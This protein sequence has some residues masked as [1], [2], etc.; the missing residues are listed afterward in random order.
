N[1]KRFVAAE[2]PTSI[3]PQWERSPKDLKGNIDRIFCAG[4]NRIVWHTFT[5][6]PKEFGLP[7]NEYFAGTH[8]NPNV[9]WWE[10]AGGFISY[11]NR[12][13][14]LL[15]QG[16]FVADVLYYYGD[17]VPNFVFLKDEYKELKFGYNWDKCSKD[18]LLDHASV[19]NG[20]LLLPDGMSYRLLVLPNEE[21][22]NLEVLKKV[23]E[24]VKQGLTVIS[25][26]P[27]RATGLTNYPESDSEIELIVKRMWG[28]VNGENVTE[29]KYG[30]GHVVWGQDVNEVLVGMEVHPDLKF[31]STNE[32]T[33]LDFI[34]RTTDNQ[35][36][37]F[38]VNRYARKGI[39]D[40]KYRYLTD[41]P[42][43][44]EQV[45]C[46]FRVTGKVPELWDP[47]TGNI[48]KQLV[49]KEEGEYT[50]IPLHFEPEGSKFI[51]FREVEKDEPHITNITK[52][53]RSFFP[54]NQFETKPNPYIEL[55]NED[56]QFRAHVTEPGDFELTW[57]DGEKS[58][59]KVENTIAEQPISGSWELS[60][61]TAW[62]GP[63]KVSIDELKSWTEFSDEG[64]K[65]YSGTATYNKS[66]SISKKEIKNKKLLLDLGNVQEMT[67]I[68]INGQQMPV[69]WSAPFVFDI[70]KH[71]KAGIN[72]LEVEVV[73]MWPN[74]LILDGRLPEE[75]RLT[76]TN[77]SKFETED[78][79]KYLRA[80]GLLG[81]VKVRFFKNVALRKF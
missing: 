28:N 64:I 36:I 48:T 9:T 77:V 52:D 15:Q 61:D 38:V 62:G 76:M 27:V 67:S 71:V 41:L 30:E 16:L 50:I 59:V 45:E 60:F 72:N 39:S 78:A 3:G 21:G 12:C 49:Y 22:I 20:K 46:K 80:S 7:G 66:F 26:R 37:F 25:P 31:I 6:S 56:G 40:F 8:L 74:R 11:L 24:L 5:S 65:Y 79:E 23:E 58:L 29:N 68:K 32:N 55:I 81:P 53:G 75:K 69:K 4:V 10:Q 70:T 17:D 33:A 18:V 13:S 43:R 44:Y 54:G 51:I 47:M 63:E 2:G 42:D 14:F 57:S 35:E 34:H 1:G 73:N 19:E